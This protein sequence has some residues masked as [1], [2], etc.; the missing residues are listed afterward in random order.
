M[1]TTFSGIKYNPVQIKTFGAH[2]L[3]TVIPVSMTVQFFLSKCVQ[4]SFNN[5]NNKKGFD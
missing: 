1:T 5:N 3:F 4:L 2:K